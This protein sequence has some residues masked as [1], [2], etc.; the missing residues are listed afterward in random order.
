MTF[1]WYLS[2]FNYLCNKIQMNMYNGERKNSD[3]L[4]AIRD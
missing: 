3:T 1:V 4:A 2:Y